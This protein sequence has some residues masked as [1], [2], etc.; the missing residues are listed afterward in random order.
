MDDIDVINPKKVK[1]AV[2]QILNE[3]LQIGR[4]TLQRHPILEYT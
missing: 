3:I 2:F 4:R 1:D